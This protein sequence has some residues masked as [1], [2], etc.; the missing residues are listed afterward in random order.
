MPGRLHKGDALRFCKS[1]MIHRRRMLRRVDDIFGLGGL[2]VWVLQHLIH[3]FP[4]SG[5][6]SGH[7]DNDIG[8]RENREGRRNRSLSSGL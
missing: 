2:D 8:P 4:L 1:R 7:T 5:P 6:E 3:G